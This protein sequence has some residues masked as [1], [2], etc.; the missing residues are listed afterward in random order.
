MRTLACQTDQMAANR[1]LEFSGAAIDTGVQRSV[2]GRSQ[3]QAYCRQNGI[4]MPLYSSKSM[5]SFADQRCPSQ[6]ILSVTVPTPGNPLR[7][8]VDVVQ[9]HIPILLGLDV[10][11]KHCL[12]FLSTENAFQ[13]VHE[14]WKLLVVRKD[15]HSFFTWPNIFQIM[16]SRPQLERLH[17]HFVNPSAVKLHSLLRPT[18]LDSLSDET[19]QVLQDIG[20]ACHTCQV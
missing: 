9:P 10:L 6:G 13:A 17:R 3:A 14:G 11:D 15:G 8:N 16:F 4:P 19:L 1:D 2:I 18:N 20:N 7:L 12:Q 5:F